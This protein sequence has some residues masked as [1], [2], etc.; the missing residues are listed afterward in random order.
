MSQFKKGTIIGSN[1]NDDARYIKDLKKLIQSSSV[2]SKDP[3][4]YHA[5]HEVVFRVKIIN[6]KK[7]RDRNEFLCALNGPEGT[8]YEGGIMV[9]KITRSKRYPWESSKVTPMSW[10]FHPNIKNNEICLDILKGEWKPSLDFE[11]LI[12]SF[13]SFLMEPNPDDPLNFPVNEIYKRH[14]K[15]YNQYVRFITQ[16]FMNEKCYEMIKNDFIN[17]TSKYSNSLPFQYSSLYSYNAGTSGDDG[18]DIEVFDD[19]ECEYSD[20]SDDTGSNSQKIMT[21]LD[22]MMN[23]KKK[24]QGDKKKNTSDDSGSG[25]CSNSEE[26]D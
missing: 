6:G 10:F 2:K 3:S 9:L 17:G 1:S 13:V 16:N 5:V 23:P 7:K 15:K 25:T 8:I 4:Q 14:K 18:S 11:A 20:D 21:I 24:K 26:V 22:R 19:S 12:Q